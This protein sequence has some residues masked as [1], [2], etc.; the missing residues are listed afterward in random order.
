MWNEYRKTVI[1]HF[2][3]SPTNKINSK[4]YLLSVDQDHST[5]YRELFAPSVTAGICKPS[6]LAGYRNR[7]VFISNS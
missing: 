4:D 7:P 5:W 3:I 1:K 2:P 6:D